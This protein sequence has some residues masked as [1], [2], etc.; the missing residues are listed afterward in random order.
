MY[1]GD[2]CNG[3]PWGIGTMTWTYHATYH[4][5]WID[6]KKSG[7]GKYTLEHN[8]GAKTDL[9]T[10]K[11]LSHDNSLGLSL[12]STENLQNFQENET[13]QDSSDNDHRVEKKD[14]FEYTNS[15]F[16]STQNETLKDIHTLTITESLHGNHESNSEKISILL[17]LLKP[18][19]VKNYQY[20]IDNKMGS[21]I[22][23][24]HPDFKSTGSYSILDLSEAT[25]QD[26][27]NL[28]QA[29][30]VDDQFNSM[31]FPKSLV[32]DEDEVFA[33]SSSNDINDNQ[34]VY[35]GTWDNDQVSKKIHVNNIFYTNS[36]HRTYKF[37]IIVLII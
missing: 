10:A 21:N 14:S 25:S 7:F 12:L 16:N 27:G 8:F 29:Q 24:T 11:S 17:V 1:S 13:N 20:T 22:Y 33:I 19:S 6:G 15:F 36:A 2:L 26:V 35:Q 4:G 31:I 30:N 28:Q 3:I 18:E 37:I 32:P 5:S 23:N 9:E 34:D